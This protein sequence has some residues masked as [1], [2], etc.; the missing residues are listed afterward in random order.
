MEKLAVALISVLVASCLSAG[1]VQAPNAT[2]QAIPPVANQRPQTDNGKGEIPTFYSQARQVLITVSVWKHAAKSAAWVPQ[3][4]LKRYPVAADALAMPPVAQGLSA[5]D[6]RIFDNGAEQKI[7]Y[8]E[9]SD[10]SVRDV[11][12]QWSFHP[13][14]RGTWG[15]FLSGD[16]SL[17]SPTATYIV[18]YIPPPLQSGDCHTVRVVAGDN[19]VVLNRT[20]YCNTDEGDTAT[21]EGGKLAAKLE[22]F[23]KS[24]SRGSI[25]V[26]S[27]P[28]VFWSSGVLSLM[29][30]KTASTGSASASAAANYTYVVVVHDSR[31]PATVQIATE[32]EL[33]TKQWDYPCPS[34]HPAI[35]VFGIVYKT[36]GEVAARFGDSYPCRS[37]L[38]SSLYGFVDLPAGSNPRTG[39]LIPTRFNTQVELR[40]GDYDVHV[41]VSDGHK[42][43]QA[44]MPLRVEPIDSQ[45]LTISDIALNGILRDASWLLRDAAMVSPA[46]LVP[47][48]LVSKH[49]QFMP[50]ADARLPK[51]TSLPLYFEIYE[52][53]LADR[54]AEVYFRI[55]ITD[56]KDGTVVMNAGPTSAAQCVI[57]G[58]VVIPIALKVDTDKLQS[59]QYKIEVQA[60][61]SA[62]RTTEWRTAKFEI[63]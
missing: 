62:G 22:T 59:G 7:N 24:D 63:Q 26:S 52:P 34:D 39:E 33:G 4:A 13:H 23:A 38:S 48:P 61:D 40:P 51:N 31:A 58:N 3:G 54:S 29:R 43:G 60:S 46:P 41:V 8:L 50:V 35:Y 44:R 17:A 37:E 6:F 20:R 16:L 32:Y 2:V 15:G 25:K 47:A 42:F 14:I 56:L 36:N 1:Q 49:A 57:P 55:K 9:E 53:L 11:N 5:N 12:E 19:E 18:G 21:V 10:S 45:A 27:Q 28:F 30:D